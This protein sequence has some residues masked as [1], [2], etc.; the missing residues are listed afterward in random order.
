MMKIYHGSNQKV[1]E[2]N[3][4]TGRKNLDFGCG[5]YATS[6]F[7]QAKSWSK[8]KTNRVGWGRPIVNIY[9]LD[10]DKLSNL[11]VL[12][13]LEPN[14]QWLEFVVSNR[15]GLNKQDKYDVVIGP[16]ANDSTIFVINNYISGGIDENTALALL[17][18]QKLKDQYTFLSEEALACLKFLKEEVIDE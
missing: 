5:F 2:P 12:K 1:I 15:K 6:D 7:D 11:R 17:L 14:K 16:I 8:A 9:E 3:I 10:T 4:K 13:F 18:P